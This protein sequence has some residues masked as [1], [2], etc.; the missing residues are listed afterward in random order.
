MKGFNDK[1]TESIDGRSTRDKQETPQTSA[2]ETM[3][4]VAVKILYSPT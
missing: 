1:S 4:M 2:D 3:G